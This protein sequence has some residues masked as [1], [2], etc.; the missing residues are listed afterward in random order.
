MS[1][2]L[3]ALPCLL[4][5]ACSS[6]PN[7]NLPSG[8]VSAAAAD[9][10]GKSAD[11]AGRPWRR[12]QQVEVAYEGEWTRIVPKLQPELVNAD[13]R[14]SSREVYFPRL[15][16]VEQTH[17][18]PRGTKT[19]RRIPGKVEV[20]LPVYRQPTEVEKDAAALVADAYTM[21]T[22]GA[23][24]LLARG[25]DWRIWPAMKRQEI[26]GDPCSLVFGT[27]RPGVGRSE[28]DRVIAWISQRDHRLR[29][30]QFT[31]N[32]LESTAG[33]DVDVTFSDFQPGPQGTEWPRQFLETV[34]R[35][36]TVKAHEWRMTDLKVRQ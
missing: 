34:R 12:F 30:V 25:R 1:K 3:L 18:G 15:N 28:E 4:L 33:A 19:V 8:Q 36:L 20:H 17:T 23:D 9:L 14:K 5:A 2:L 6:L 13:Y 21:F 26:D 27:L 29:R 22:F 24:Y 35:P 32:G 11:Q 16:R 7:P 10:L 31:L